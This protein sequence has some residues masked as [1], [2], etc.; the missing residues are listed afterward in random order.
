MRVRW[1]TF[2]LPNRV[3]FEELTQNYGKVIAEPFERGF[4]TTVGNS[5]RRILLSSIEGAA[6]TKVQIKG[7]DHE[8][9]SID[10]IREDVE[11]IILNLKEVLLKMEVREEI[12]FTLKAEKKGIVTAG[13]II[14]D[15]RFQVI[16]KDHYICELVKDLDLE[17]TLWA[18][19]GRGYVTAEENS[20]GESEIGIIPLDSIFSPIRRVKYYT[21]DT[22]V[23][24]ITDYD[25]LIMEIWTDGTVDPKTALTEA[26]KIMR[27][28]LNSFVQYT[29]LGEPFHGSSESGEWMESTEELVSQ[30]SEAANESIADLK[31][32]KKVEKETP[33]EESNDIRSQS[34]EILNLGKRSM[35]GLEYS[36]IKT[37]G[38]LI[39]FTKED[40][41]KLP[42]IGKKS[43]DEIE[44]KLNEIGLTFK[45]S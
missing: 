41:L 6:I 4:G 20:Q 5:L 38:E 17:M 24:K 44:E 12:Q 31:E 28:H 8:Y 27:K 15:H 21:E 14:E 10:G 13:N 40:L 9:T 26:A 34:V 18:K 33:K 32:D 25:R 1:R 3:N 43:V 39:S 36:K 30:I 42:K 35:N 23:G 19:K 11:D 29:E 16:N 22:R 2:E 37:I 7:V 45:E